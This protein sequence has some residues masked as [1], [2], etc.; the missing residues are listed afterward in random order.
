MSGIM[1][2]MHLY[3]LFVSEPLS[4]SVCLYT[5][6]LVVFQHGNHLFM[7]LGTKILKSCQLLILL[8]I[9]LMM[10]IILIWRVVQQWITSDTQCWRTK[11]ESRI[12][13]RL[14]SPSFAR[15]WCWL[16]QMYNVMGALHDC[17]AA[18]STPVIACYHPF[19]LSV[20]ILQL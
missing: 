10:E 6:F 13:V 4:W 3:M 5:I 14:T 17:H 7:L 16:S 19:V 20:I 15:R 12:T 1:Y 8:F 9:K 18:V 2:S 11:F